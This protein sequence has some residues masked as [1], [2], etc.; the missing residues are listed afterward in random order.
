MTC[1]QVPRPQATL[2]WPV[3]AVRACGE[4]EEGGRTKGAGA[5]QLRGRNPGRVPLCGSEP[6][7]PP[8]PWVRGA[9]CL[10]AAPGR[11]RA[12][13]RARPLVADRHSVGS[14]GP[15]GA[16]LSADRSARRPGARHLTAKERKA[17]ETAVRRASGCSSVKWHDDCI[18]QGCSDDSRCTPV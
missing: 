11:A 18:L 4:R 3:Q 17:A 16:P 1:E 14:R 15:R 2:G 5:G 9:W 8:A 7:W 10:L 13:G 6:A 12:Q